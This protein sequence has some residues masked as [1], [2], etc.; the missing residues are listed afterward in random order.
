MPVLASRP[1]RE[2]NSDRRPLTALRLNLSASSALQPQ[3]LIASPPPPT[4]PKKSAPVPRT[5]PKHTRPP[6]T[7][8]R[9]HPT[10]SGDTQAWL[11]S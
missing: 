3:R 4:P 6:A 7:L 9:L 8:P 5:A 11:P 2:G 1:S 10:L